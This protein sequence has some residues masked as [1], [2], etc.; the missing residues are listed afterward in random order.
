MLA[1]YFYE[2]GYA[3]LPA[4]SSGSVSPPEPGTPAQEST[5]EAMRTQARYYI[6]AG[7]AAGAGVMSH[8]N[9]LYILAAIWLLIL[10]DHGRKLFRTKKLYQFSFAAFAVMAYEILYDIIDFKNFRL[11]NRDDTL[12][13]DVFQLWGWWKNLSR[14]P[15][16][17]WRWWLGWE[18][19]PELPQAT[20]LI[21]QMLTSHFSAV[22]CND[23]Q[24]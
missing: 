19:Y 22:P 6:A 11:Q 24:P 14:E 2:S 3:S 1:Y 10:F 5:P 21:F 13:F 8:T 23:N 16:R 7:L 9:I 18:S 20:L 4:C 15:K 12:H 17:Y